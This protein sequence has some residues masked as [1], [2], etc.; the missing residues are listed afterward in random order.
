MDKTD[1][2]RRNIVDKREIYNSDE[3]GMKRFDKRGMNSRKK[4]KEQKEQLNKVLYKT[5]FIF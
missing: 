4:K 5:S 2:R 1:E 3:K